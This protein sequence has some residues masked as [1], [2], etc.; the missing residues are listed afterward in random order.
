MAV[1]STKIRYILFTS[2]WYI[3][4]GKVNVFSMCKYGKVVSRQKGW[5][6][7]HTGCLGENNGPKVWKK[8]EYMY[9]LY[10][11]LPPLF[12]LWYMWSGG[13]YAYSPRPLLVFI[14]SIIFRWSYIC[15]ALRQTRNDGRCITQHYTVP[16]ANS[17]GNDA[18]Y[19]TQMFPGNN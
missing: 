9:V 7:V 4:D 5:G 12:L 10:D 18:S 16:G 2:L 11:F 17:E 13:I 1:I 6:R 8:M 3:A 15:I 19:T 14:L